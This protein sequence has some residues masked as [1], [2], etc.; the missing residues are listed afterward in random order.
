MTGRWVTGRR[1]LA[2]AAALAA[3]GGGIA[4]LSGTQSWATATARSAVSAMPVAVSG[5]TAAPLATAA[6][7]VGLAAVGALLATRRAGRTLVGLLLVLAGVAAGVAV[8]RFLTDPAGARFSTV[9][10]DGST[11]PA[12]AAASAEQV[13]VS[14]WP[15][16]TCTAAL[17]MLLAGLGAALAGRRWPALGRRYETPQ[18]APAG[19]R[20]RPT[21]QAPGP[22]GYWDD[23]DAGRDPTAAGPE[24]RGR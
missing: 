10:I 4:A 22:A 23:I 17:L 3:A 7:V 15:W 24:D 20:A 11:V 6:G 18:D 14:A 16:L 2:A 8:G 5:G 9:G 13:A 1:G 12:T 19:G 21:G